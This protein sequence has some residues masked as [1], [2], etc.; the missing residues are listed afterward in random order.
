MRLTDAKIE[1]SLRAIGE[2]VESGIGIATYLENPAASAMLPAD[3][4][5]V[6][7]RSIQSGETLAHA[8]DRT[9]LFSPAELALLSAGEKR[10]NIDESLFAMADAVEARRQDRA[11]LIKGLAYPAFLLAFAGCV[12]PVPTIITDGVLS[13]L[14]VAIWAPLFVG[15]L[16]A[17]VLFVLPRLNPSSKMRSMPRR[18]AMSLP[19][20][21]RAFQRGT[22]ATFLDVLGKGISAGMPLPTALQ[23]AILGSDNPRLISREAKMMAALS[24]GAT[25]ADTLHASRQFENQVIAAVAQGEIT[26]KLD[27]VLPR[28]ASK[29]RE[30]Q[31]RAA[32]ALMFV[33]IGLVAIA[34]LSVIVT[35]LIKGV[36]GYFD[37]IDAQLESQTR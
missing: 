13:Y 35:S 28:A 29:E 34:V 5:A 9:G 11:K 12:L 3:F 22:H 17:Y 6:L 14:S 37:F 32:S 27:K 10:G 23:A 19:F 24:G 15:G 33:V 20:F 8:F 4:R 18:F 25:L 2:A 26:G 36:T 31:R 30:V 7:L 1:S 21:G 16:T